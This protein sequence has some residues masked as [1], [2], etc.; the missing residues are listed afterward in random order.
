MKKHSCSL[1][2]EVYTQH[3]GTTDQNQKSKLYE[4]QPK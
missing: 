4:M 3:A 1:A 2:I